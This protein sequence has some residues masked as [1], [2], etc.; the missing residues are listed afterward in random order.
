MAKHGYVYQGTE[1]GVAKAK[2]RG[3]QISPKHAFEVA[4]ALKGRTLARGKSFLERVIDQTE[5]VPFKRYNH[6][7]GH[8]KG[9]GPG[10]FPKKTSEAFLKLLNEV[11]ANADFKGMNKEKLRIKHI[12]TTKGRVVQGRYKGGRHNTPTTHVEVVVEEQ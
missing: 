10:A 4:A 2:G 5:A 1:E 7:V 6:G 11:E 3:Y 8:K 12:V 9:V